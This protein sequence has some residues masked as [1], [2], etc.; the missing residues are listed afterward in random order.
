MPLIDWNNI[1]DRLK[2]ELRTE[3]DADLARWLD[4]RP[5]QISK[6]RSGS[7][8]DDDELP[9]HSKFI[10]LDHFGYFKA[11]DFALALLTKKARAKVLAFERRRTQG[12]AERADKKKGRRKP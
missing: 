8:P 10:A 11:R 1:F 12:I 9:A 4:A 5:E 7:A 2:A 6:A 3:S